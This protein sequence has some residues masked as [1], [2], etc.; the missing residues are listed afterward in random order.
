MKKQPLI[1]KQ[2]IIIL[3]VIY[4]KA[5]KEEGNETEY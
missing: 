2:W 4:Y 1:A 3:I 5:R